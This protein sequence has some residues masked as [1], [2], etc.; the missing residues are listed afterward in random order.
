[1][2]LSWLGIREPGH[3][4]QAEPMQVFMAQWQQHF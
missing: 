3:Q 2:K 1:V 4:A